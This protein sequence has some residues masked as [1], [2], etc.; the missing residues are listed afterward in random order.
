MS[1]PSAPFRFPPGRRSRPARRRAV[2]SISI[3]CVSRSFW[4]RVSVRDFSCR[5]R[6]RSVDS[7]AAISAASSSRVRSISRVV[8]S[9]S[10]MMRASLRARSC[11]M[12]AVS[13]CSR[14]V[15]SSDSIV[16]AVAI[17]RRRISTSDAIRASAMARSLAMRA[18]SMVS[19]AVICAHSA[20]VSRSARSCASSARCWARRNSTSRSCSSRA[21]SL[22][23][24]ISSALLLGFQVARADLDR[25]V[26]LDVVAQLAPVL[27]VLDED[28][29][30][31]GVEPVG[32]IEELE[33]RLV[34]VED[35]DGFE[36]ETVARQVGLHRLAA[37]A[38]HSWCGSRAF[39]SCPSPRRPHAL[40]SRTCR[41]AARAGFPAR[42]CAARAW[43]RPSTLRG[44]RAGRG[45]R[46]R[47]RRRR[48]CDPS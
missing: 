39:R 27:D 42:A 15:I 33:A 32:G 6:A 30:A 43:R 45:R 36:L 48:A 18:R 7:R 16:C 22:A 29:E 11:R 35:G 12:R 31:L 38:R 37:R 3:D 26:L 46:I 21:S 20:W 10:L 13:T 2:R 1:A 40:R 5:M 28:G 23:R 17:S 25:R 41:R 8:V 4:M 24:S 9:C 47:P 19:R 44:A 14:A 34:D